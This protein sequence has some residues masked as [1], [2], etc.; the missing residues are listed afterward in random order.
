[1]TKTRSKNKHKLQRLKWVFFIR[2]ENKI[3]LNWKNKKN[4]HL[5]ER[6][7]KNQYSQT[8]YK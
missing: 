3:S 4:Q 7:Y 6:K 2:M 8:N 5:I 1:M